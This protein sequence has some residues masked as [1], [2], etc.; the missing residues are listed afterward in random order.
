MLTIKHILFPC[1]FSEQCSA[2]VPFVMAIASRFDARVTLLTVNPPPWTEPPAAL[3]AEAAL[4]TRELAIEPQ[5]RLETMLVEEFA[6]FPVQTVSVSGDPALKITAFAHDNAVDLIMMPTHGYGVFRSL[7]IGS[8]TA[9][10]LHDA[11]CPVW[12]ATHAEEQQPT[13]MPR[14]ILCAVDGTPKSLEVLEWA[15]AF[16]REMGSTMKLIHVAL[17]IS[18]ALALPSEEALQD[19]VNQQARA[20][21]ESLQKSAGVE[22]SLEIAVGSVADAVAQAAEQQGVNLVLIGRGSLQATL[23]RL[24]TH[25]YGIIHKSPCPVLSV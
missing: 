8:V 13:N 17:R 20:K 22:A 10:V 15:S 4:D 16:S 21:I 6:G 25:A 19:E 24:R 12:T 23:G 7:L 1:D 5:S 3:E 18:D 9:K 11:K 14:I 2:A